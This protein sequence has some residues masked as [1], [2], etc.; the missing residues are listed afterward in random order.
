MVILK[1][2]SIFFLASNIYSSP[3]ANVKALWIVRDHMINPDLIDDALG[4]A[5]NNGFNHIFVQVRG[6]G[7]SFYNSEFVPKSILVDPN[8]DPLNYLINKCKSKNI[9]VHAW[10]NVYYLWSS[11]KHPPQN[12]HLFFQRPEWIDQELSLIHI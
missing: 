10:I 8:F 7:D 3:D 9:K 11:K 1:F 4:F 6:R 12:D 2:I 5:E